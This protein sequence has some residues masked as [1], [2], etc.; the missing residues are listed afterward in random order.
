MYKRT[1]I[2]ATLGPASSDAETISGLIQAGATVFRINFSHGE[3]EEHKER[4]RLVREEAEK[5]SANVALL[6]DLQGPK[7]RIAGFRKGSAKLVEGAEFALDTKHPAD[8]GDET[9]VGCSYQSLPADC[10]P[11]QTLLLDDGR[12]QLQIE[13][14]DDTRIHTKV[15]VG[16]VL[17]PKKGIN[18]L[19]GGLSAPALTEKDLK[20]LD[21]ATDMEIDYLAISFP[22]TAEDMHYARECAEKAGCKAR[23]IAKIERAETVADDKTLDDIICASDAV[24]VARG[25]LGVEIGDAGLIGVQKKIIRRAR[26]LNRSVI[27]ATQMMETM[28]ENSIPTRAEVFDVAN[29]VLDGTDAVMLSAE[30]ATGKHPITVVEAMSRIALGAEKQRSTQVSGHRMDRQ[31]QETEDAIAMASMYAANHMPHVKAIICLTESGNTPLLMS[32][33]RSGIPI[34]AMSEHQSTLNRMALFRGVIP[35]YYDISGNNRN[36]LL[37][38][39]VEQLKGNGFLSKGDIVLGTRGDQVGEGGMTNTLKIFEV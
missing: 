25:D 29:A 32:R 2:I 10:Q 15:I 20:D 9:V 31:F 12:L 35:R 7:I 33:I 17:Y 21:V 39:A 1:K 23:L 14:I 37:S 34:F 13:S 28:I 18:L 4:A 19:G 16:G 8:E 30:T 36:T 11:G 22:R 26:Q 38:D 6:G 3:P 24:M 27:T 5:L